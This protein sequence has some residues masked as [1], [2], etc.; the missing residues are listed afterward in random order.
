MSIYPI[1]GTYI[2]HRGSYDGCFPLILV[3]AIAYV[4]PESVYLLSHQRRYFAFSSRDQFLAHVSEFSFL[5]QK[6]IHTFSLYLL[7][8]LPDKKR[9][10]RTNADTKFFPNFEIVKI[11]HFPALFSPQQDFC[12]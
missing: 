6:N 8:I 9:H 5:K 2:A 11:K 4:F 3:K 10:K 7:R 12:F 1:N